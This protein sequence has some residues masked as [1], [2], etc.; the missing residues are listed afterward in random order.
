MR[1]DQSGGVRGLSR[2]TAVSI[3]VL[4]TP[5]RVFARC[6]PGGPEQTADLAREQVAELQEDIQR[7]RVF[8]EKVG[9]AEAKFESAP[10]P[11]LLPLPGGYVKPPLFETERETPFVIE[12]NSPA[13]KNVQTPGKQ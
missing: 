10:A 7:Q 9:E 1:R 6:Y 3:L 4:H 5:L 2:R 13:H 12:S 11:A 8:L